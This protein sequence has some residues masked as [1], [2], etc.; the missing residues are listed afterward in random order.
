LIGGISVRASRVT[1][2][3]IVRTQKITPAKCNPAY[4]AQ[5][6]LPQIEAGYYGLGRRDRDYDF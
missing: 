6:E 5:D 3:A 4:G 2:R 1:T